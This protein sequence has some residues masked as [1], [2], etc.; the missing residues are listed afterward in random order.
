MS[1]N[2][3]GW[4]GAF[5]WGTLFA[6]APDVDWRALPAGWLFSAYVLFFRARLSDRRRYPTMGEA[7]LLVAANLWLGA[8][9]F[10]KPFLPGVTSQVARFMTRNVTIAVAALPV[11]LALV[12]GLS[13]PV[14]AILRRQGRSAN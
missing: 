8:L 2:A 10:L 11:A 3:I 6:L 14:R 7:A 9:V 12:A 4:V 1:R 5:L 13:R